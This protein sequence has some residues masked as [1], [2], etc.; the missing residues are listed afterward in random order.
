M[1]GN[2]RQQLSDEMKSHVVAVHELIDSK[3]QERLS[4]FQDQIQAMISQVVSPASESTFEGYS[5][6]ST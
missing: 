2:L 5:T 3:L 4:V 1:H 6:K